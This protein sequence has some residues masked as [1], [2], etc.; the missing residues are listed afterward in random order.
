MSL[1]PK[2][3]PNFKRWYKDDDDGTPPRAK[4]LESGTTP[5]GLACARYMH[6]AFTVFERWSKPMHLDWTNR[7]EA[8]YAFLRLYHRKHPPPPGITSPPPALS[9][10]AW[11]KEQ[12]ERAAMMA[13]IRAELLPI[14][15]DPPWCHPRS[16]GGPVTPCRTN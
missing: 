16:T 5:E 13:R 4:A 10:A 12:R 8:L 7:G 9:P 3:K 2:R 6:R 14:A 15:K 1:Q 11:E